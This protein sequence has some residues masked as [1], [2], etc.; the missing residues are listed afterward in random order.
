M[1]RQLT[2]EADVLQHLS[3][4]AIS[5]ADMAVKTGL[6]VGFV[7]D[8]ATR[9]L[10]PV[11]SGLE[12]ESTSTIA[13]EWIQE[14]TSALRTLGP[15]SS[16]DF[17][18]DPDFQQAAQRIRQ[19]LDE[20]LCREMLRPSEED[21]RRESQELSQCLMGNWFSLIEHAKQDQ[22][23][24]S[25][26]LDTHG[27]P[28][29]YSLDDLLRG[30]EAFPVAR[31]ELVAKFHEFLDAC[32]ADGQAKQLAPDLFLTRLPDNTYEVT[33]FDAATEISHAETGIF[34]SVV[35][36]LGNGHPG[37]EE[38]QAPIPLCAE[39]LLARAAANIAQTRDF[40]KSVR[41]AIREI[42]RQAM[43]LKFAPA[44]RKI[45]ASKTL[46]ETLAKMAISD[47]DDA[48]SP[49]YLNP[50]RAWNHWSAARNL[51]GKAPIAVGEAAVSSLR[52][53]SAVASC[54]VV[55]REARDIEAPPAGDMSDLI[56]VLK[57][58]PEAP[59]VLYQS[60]V[61]AHKVAYTP[62]GLRLGQKMCEHFAA[63]RT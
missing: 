15:D 48:L 34:E 16:G 26:H 45:E 42:K 20:Q 55:A 18:Q 6:F 23:P 62:D 30:I 12:A 21:I 49:N 41:T 19:E 8:F 9:I 54:Y 10:V 22:Q 27:V 28:A 4:Q 52:R 33:A 5:P 47:I 39:N 14:A 32:F 51:R 57:N 43:D 3:S 24:K 44:L 31:V 17:E 61:A 58:Y 60:A 2:T 40:R 36:L 53:V 59:T 46:P 38:N 35:D 29:N 7:H 56:D 37:V 63:N 50:L 11:R 13:D 25:V 1:A